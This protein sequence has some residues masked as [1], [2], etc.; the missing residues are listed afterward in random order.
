MV[1][2][3]W[4]LLLFGKAAGWVGGSV[5]RRGVWVGAEGDKW[6]SRGAQKLEANYAVVGSWRAESTEDIEYEIDRKVIIGRLPRGADAPYLR[7]VLSDAFGPVVY[8]DV[9]ELDVAYVVFGDPRDA[10]DACR[11]SV[12]VRCGDDYEFKIDCEP[13]EA[14]VEPR[15][16]KRVFVGNLPY[17]GVSNDLLKRVFT[18]AGCS[19]PTALRRPYP[20]IAY[21]EFS[22][23]QDAERAVRLAGTRVRGR[24]IRVDWDLDARRPKPRGAPPVVREEQVSVPEEEVPEEEVPEAEV[25]EAEVPEESKVVVKKKGASPLMVKEPETTAKKSAAKQETADES[26]EPPKPARE[27]AREKIDPEPAAEPRNVS[28]A[29]ENAALPPRWQLT[30]RD[31]QTLETTSIKAAR[32]AA[33]S[34]AAAWREARLL[35]EQNAD[36]R[37][38][39]PRKA[40]WQPEPLALRLGAEARPGD[41]LRLRIDGT[42]DLELCVPPQA[43]PGALLLVRGALQ[44][45][46]PRGAF[47]GEPLAVPLP[48]TDQPAVVVVPPEKRPGSWLWVAFPVDCVEPPNTLPPTQTAIL[49]PP[50]PAKPKEPPY[51]LAPP[52]QNNF[53]LAARDALDDLEAENAQL[54]KE[55]TTLRRLLKTTSQLLSDRLEDQAAAY[56]D[57]L[58]ETMEEEDSNTTTSPGQQEYESTAEGKPRRS[59][60]ASL[61]QQQQ[62]QQQRQ[63]DDLLHQDTPQPASS[64]RRR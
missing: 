42:R 57:N 9:N 2:V 41:V 19:R 58:R 48:G 34:A 55:L 11:T 16:A 45:V 54:R 44:C 3:V 29:Q 60:P 6:R 27:E 20:G 7:D 32:A 37:S 39:V 21:V 10:R 31:A 4:L 64:R 26:P 35:R 1:V 23:Q 15:N 59:S 46:V 63:D 8:V 24:P 14:R 12:R 51:L 53:A 22:T 62:Q 33:L 38:R 40:T 47:P 36:L 28:S 25:P 17:D 56:V 52:A 18:G 43:G 49:L 61:Q 13:F 50:P 30:A 5:P